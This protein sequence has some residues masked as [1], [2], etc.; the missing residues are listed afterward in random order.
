MRPVGAFIRASAQGERSHPALREATTAS[1]LRPHVSALSVTTCSCLPRW[2]ATREHC[3]DSEHLLGFCSLRLHSPHVS[4]SDSLG[5]Q[6]ALF[7]WGSKQVFLLFPSPGLLEV[8]ITAHTYRS[9]RLFQ[10]VPL[11]HSTSP[12]SVGPSHAMGIILKIN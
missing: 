8:L 6:R 1:P 9:D 4:P 11:S 2:F 3:P 10:Q 5:K 12:L 7:F